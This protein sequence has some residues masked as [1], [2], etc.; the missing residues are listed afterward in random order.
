[1]YL[2][3]TTSSV[4]QSF[5]ICELT[6]P[7]QPRLL[8]PTNG[9]TGIGYANVTFNWTASTPTVINFS[10][11]YLFIFSSLNSQFSPFS[12]GAMRNLTNHVHSLPISKFWLLFPQL[13]WILALLH[14]SH[15]T[16][17]LSLVRHCHRFQEFTITIC[18]FLVRHNIFLLSRCQSGC[19]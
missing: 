1:M 8:L 3:L 11:I 9:E 7:T 19:P 12:L 17:F 4:V 5:S 16:W 18:H 6:A 14:H 15:S 13:H 10:F 2:G